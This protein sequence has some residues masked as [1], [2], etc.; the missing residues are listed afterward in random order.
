MDSRD[1]YCPGHHL[2]GVDYCLWGVD[3][4]AGSFGW[5]WGWGSGRGDENEV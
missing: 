4:G 3:Q 1:D 2:A 5:G